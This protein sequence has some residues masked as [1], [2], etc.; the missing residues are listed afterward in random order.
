MPFCLFL[1]LFCYGLKVFFLDLEDKVVLNWIC[2]SSSFRAAH[3]HPLP[4]PGFQAYDYISQGIVPT[5]FRGLR[6]IP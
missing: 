5:K 4:L 2:K 3:S 6:M 1:N